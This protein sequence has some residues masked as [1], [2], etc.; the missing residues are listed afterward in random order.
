[1]HAAI[2]AGGRGTRATAMTWDS[3]PKAL[4]PV[5]G[6]PIIIHQMRVLAR[7]RVK[8]ITVLAGHLGNQLHPALS[9]E[10]E[11]LGMSLDIILEDTPRGTAGCLVDL[12]PSAEDIFIIYGDMLFDVALQPLQD[13]HRRQR[14]VLTIVGHPNDHPRTSD[15][16]VEED[17]LVKAFLPL[18]QRPEKDYRNLV[19]A[20]L[21][22]A[23]PDFFRSLSPGKT[24]DLSHEVIPALLAAGARIAVYNTPEYMRDVGSLKRHAMA[25][26]DLA[27]GLPE[28]LNKAHRRPAIFFDCDGVLNEEPGLHGAIKPDDIQLIDGASESVRR[29]REAGMLTVAVTNRPQIAKGFVSFD[30]LSRILGRL[31]ALLAADGGVLDRIYFCPHYPEGGFPGEIAALKVHCEC[32]KPGALLLR[33][34]FAELPIDM[35]RS[36]IIGDSLRDIGAGRRANIWCYGVRT[37]HGCRDAERVWREAGIK[38]IPDLMFADVV[39]AVDFAVNYHALGQQIVSTMPL[40]TALE[41][42]LMIAIC[43][44]SRSGKSVVAHAVE[45][46]LREQGRNCLRVPLDGWIIPSAQRTPISTALE[47]VKIRELHGVLRDLCER[48]VVKTSGYDPVTRAAAGSIIYDPT[49]ADIIII[50][51]ILAAHATLRPLLD[52]VVFLEAPPDLLRSR[53]QAFYRWKGLEPDAIRTLWDSRAAEEWPVVEAQRDHAHLVISSKAN[54]P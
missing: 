40:P 26:R 21:Y 43:G 3:I 28:A 17:G 20:G 52:F 18:G 32:R 30:G 16:I 54:S 41:R 1:M 29:A 23:S 46:T 13:F 19:P 24:A 33:Q 36:A 12:E 7:E 27:A 2:V 48:K 10:A 25:E 49:K 15:L 4:L 47:R 44:K 6:V 9:R 50:D 42:P 34:A 37:G 31:E 35:R 5:G 45:R 8:R 38:P 22:I 11:A 51:G 39:E 14:A 53:F